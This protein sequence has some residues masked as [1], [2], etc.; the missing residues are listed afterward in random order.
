MGSPETEPDII[1]FPKQP[2]RRPESRPA[3]R[4]TTERKDGLDLERFFS[5]FSVQPLF[6]RQEKG[7]DWDHYL[8]LMR[9]NSSGV[10]G[11][12]DLRSFLLEIG[13]FKQ[14]S[15]ETLQEISDTFYDV[16][17]EMVGPLI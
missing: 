10:R 11:F 7:I 16:R 14:F 8:R 3:R 2:E 6:A 15:R 13:R 4:Q 5:L 17:D 12:E 9:T 1:P